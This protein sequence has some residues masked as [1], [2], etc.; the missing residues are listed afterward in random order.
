MDIDGDIQKVQAI[1]VKQ[2]RAQLLKQIHLK[3]QFMENPNLLRY[4]KAKNYHHN[5]T[6]ID[7]NQSK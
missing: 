7:H 5:D 1:G 2:T 3:K 4:S 6:E